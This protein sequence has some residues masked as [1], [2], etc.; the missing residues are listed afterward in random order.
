MGSLKPTMIDYINDE[1]KH[2]AV[3]WDNIQR[4]FGCCGLESFE[5]WEKAVNGTPISCCEI[6]HGILSN[7]ACNSAT[8][9]LHPVGCVKSFG[10]F[11]QTHAKTLGLAG[12]ILAIV[13]LFGL[14][15]ACL[16]ARK[17]KK[18]RGYS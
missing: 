2:I 7:F 12:I 15:F 4:N 14:F 11:I 5:D 6:P 8:S 3:G 13:Q 10:E 17:I 18:H 9:T 1:K 16:I